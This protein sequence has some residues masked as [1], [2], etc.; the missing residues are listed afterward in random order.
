[1]AETN[2]HPTFLLSQSDIGAGK[3]GAALGPAAVLTE[4]EQ[5]GYS[6]GAFET[7]GNISFEH[8]HQLHTSGKNID[9]IY[10][11]MKTL[12]DKVEQIASNGGLPF[13]FSGD[14]SNAI[15]GLSGLKN[16]FPD[17]RIGVIWV[18]A[19]ADLHSPYTTPSGNMHGM[20]L[21]ALA[22]IDNKE[23]E[24]NVVDEEVKQYWN[25]LKQLGRNHLTPKFSTEDLVFI[26]LRDTEAEERLIISQNNILAFGPDSIRQKGMEQVLQETLQH[27]SS[28]DLLY[29]SFDADSLDPNISTGTGTTAPDG[30]SVE[31]AQ[32]IFNT[33]LSHPHL[34]VFEI[35]EVN[36]SLD[37]N[38]QPMAKVVATLLVNGL[39][40]MQ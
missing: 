21:A 7:L 25:D 17:K 20:P 16:A 27:L 2:R 30:L 38:G 18:D 15:G 12:N 37:T 5:L 26:G 19:H 13:I 31:D 32:R 11:A 34:G 22:G 35:T 39:K 33:L 8:G 1:M 3:R 24:R 9:A 28:C 23:S 36:P 6:I 40:S 14:H 10:T 29:V 4:T